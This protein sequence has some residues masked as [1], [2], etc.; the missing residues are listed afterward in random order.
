[1]TTDELCRRFTY[2]KGSILSP[3]RDIRG[4]ATGDCQSFA[5][6]VLIIE[7]G[8]VAKALWA[9]L[10]FRAMI[11]RA[12]SPVNGF[13]PRHAVLCYRGRWIDSTD[14]YWRDGPAP[15]RR[16]YPAGLPVLIG[17]AMAANLWRFL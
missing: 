17:L 8:G 5:F 16:A 2:R 6:T 14:R 4:S 10:T 11:W 7:T 15:P 12:W 1:M 9:M 3:W 13:V